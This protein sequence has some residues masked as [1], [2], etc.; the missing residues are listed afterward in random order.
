MI[1]NFD[2]GKNVYEA[3]VKLANSFE[4]AGFERNSGV[5]FGI[6]MFDSALVVVVDGD[7]SGFKKYT[8]SEKEIRSVTK[9]MIGK[10][11]EI[12]SKK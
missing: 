3:I 2:L 5:E 6:G 11:G 1:G 8:G 9:F 10:H 4:N 12:F 7:V